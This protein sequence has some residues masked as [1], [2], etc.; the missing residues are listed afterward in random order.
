MN[1]ILHDWLLIQMRDNY[2][3]MLCPKRRMWDCD[4]GWFVIESKEWLLP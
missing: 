3:A 2:Y 4:Y 1:N